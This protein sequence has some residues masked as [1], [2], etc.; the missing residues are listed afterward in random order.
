MKTSYIYAPAF[1]M[2]LLATGCSEDN[3]RSP[4]NI[5]SQLPITL[6]AAYPTLTRASDAGFE[7]GDQMGVF[8]LDYVGNSP[9][10][11][12]GD[13]AH[14]A[15]VRFKFNGNDNTWSATT[16]LYW[17]SK[18]TP[19][20][21][22]GYYPFASS[23]DNP[24]SVPV[25]ISR[26]QDTTGDDNGMGGYEASDILWAKAEKVMPTDSK[27]N[28]TFRH[29][30]AGIRVTL[31]EGSGFSNGEWAQLEKVVVLPGIL[32]NTNID[33]ADGKVGEASGDRIP[34]DPYRNNSDWRAVVAPQ[35]ISAGNNLIDI[36]V[37][38]V[39]YHFA[40]NEA[41]EYISG[42]LHSFTI[43]V[44]KRSGNDGYEFKLTDEA[45][46]AWLD[47]V[48][49]RD[50]IVRNYLTINVEKRGS[51]KEIFDQKGLSTATVTGLKI[52]GEIN[53]EDFNFMREECSAL[54]S[55]NISDV[56]VW[57]G[58]RENV[59]PFAAMK[60]KTTLSHLVLPSSLQIIGN[61]AFYKTGLRGTLIIP[62]GLKK[63]GETVIDDPN[64]YVGPVYGVFGYC[65]NLRELSLPSSLEF[66][67][68][69]AF[70]NCGLTG[71]LYIPES[72]KYIGNYAFSK[73][74]FT[75][76]LTIPESV[77]FLG[78][79]S[80]EDNSF[81]GNLVIP[82]N[83]DKINAYTFHNS[84]FSGILS[85][86]QDITS[87]EIYA[88]SGCNFRGELKLPSKLQRIAGNAFSETNISS[89]IFPENLIY[90][91]DAAFR[92]CKNLKGTITIPKK[93]Q[94][95]NEYLF[96]GCQQLS[97]L[98]L[99]Q[100]IISIGGGALF[101]CHSLTRI[102]CDNPE[103]P[104]VSYDTENKYNAVEW[105]NDGYRIGPFDGI[106]KNNFTLEV[107]KGFA[108][109]YRR[110]DGWKE[111][112][113]VSESSGFYCRP[114][115]ICALNN[116]HSEN[117]V[118][119]S[120]GE[121]EIIEKP[122]WCTLSANSGDLKTAVNI[123]VN[124]LTK[125]AGDRDG[126][127]VFRLKG[128]D[129]TTECS[130]KQF[131][132]KYSGNECITLQKASKGN[133]IDI[134]FVGDGWDAASLADDSYLNLV[135]E[136][137]EAFFG[138]EPYTTYREYFNVYA[139]LSLSQETGVNTANTWRNT[140]FSTFYAHDCDGNGYLGIENVDLPF[141]YAVAHSPL[142]AIKMPNSLV[143]LT[144]NSDE[145]GSGTIMTENGSSIA[146]CCSSPD[147]YPMDTRG[148]IQHE[149]C[150]HAFGKLAEERITENRYIS[151]DEMSVI[152]KAQWRGWY[153]NISLSGKMSDV[154]W[155]E[156]IFDPRYSNSVDVFE[157]A[158][159]KTRGAFRAEINSCMNY[160]I[161][162]FSAA[163]RM[164]IMKR[165]LE[166]SGEVF[167]MEKFYATDSDKW[168]S[169]GSTRAAM[170]DA[171]NTYVGSGMHHP[172]RI[173]KSKKY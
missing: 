21:I 108:D 16:T 163:A 150:G 122:D 169:T 171:G 112:T 117:L 59:I 132:Y 72:V 148:I 52:T 173:V 4:K 5:D 141:D 114:A 110:A 143:I 20:D 83:F 35:T 125:G 65:N 67:E 124:S 68:V 10:D 144:L 120:D 101:G 103:P 44:D 58:E 50:G 84:G 172:V 170:P 62:E 18:D 138:I 135:N 105:S 168:G 155:S 139:C 33:L 46:T 160:G 86:P 25:S 42:K 40:K 77:Q 11:I 81:T 70:Y 32:P 47:D 60:N 99:P 23:I 55:L 134:L 165:I 89:I 162:Y 167:S 12:S 149:A 13:D 7:D 94:R 116:Q 130:I 80:F 123:T 158:Y 113:R 82:N 98:L 145:Y 71:T 48:E 106:A 93:V 27:V 87:I 3:L 146:I 152:N 137:M 36:S 156:L 107:P 100:D 131:D 64:Y 142:S 38:G 1:C 19:A 115:N 9:Q 127:V 15:N 111:L 154:S 159:G 14:A 161:P 49:F 85:L 28:L 153:Q 92:E 63:I 17:T 57:D 118:I 147:T 22:I 128:T 95:I 61:Q 56:T 88:F 79:G 31:I 119:N 104:L 74:K 90:L 66:I 164:D 51:L 29:V 73:N 109:A 26:R 45:I 69:G 78:K 151:N 102:V 8:V 53:E 37:D 34:V 136:Q 166:Y 39:S 54:K 133:G 121:W 140:R 43:T 30:M 24:S 126:K 91:G 41:L 96:Y 76:D 157:G 129:I 2:A 75:G 6:S 97:E